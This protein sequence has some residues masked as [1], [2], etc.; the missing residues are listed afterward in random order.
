[1]SESAQ[2]PRVGFDTP[3]EAGLS[4]HAASLPAEFEG[5][6]SR[7]H[8]RS[9]YRYDSPD[10]L[11]RGEYER[12]S[13]ALTL[14][15][16][17]VHLAEE[18][19]QEA[20]ARL[21]LNWARVSEYED[22]AAWVRRVAV[23]RARDHHRFLLRKARFLLRLADSAPAMEPAASMDPRV[24]EVIRNLPLKQRTAIALFYLADLSLA[25]VA[26]A[27]SISEGAVKRHLSRARD[28]LRAILE[29]RSCLEEES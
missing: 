7:G 17:D 12:L 18:A 4:T 28:S 8:R 25:D 11:F 2:N 26:G 19:V 23:N 22:Q 20:F 13:R 29:E 10:A 5:V 16:G 24:A 3:R 1:M 9:L 14:I 27:M 15:T 21:C 6:T